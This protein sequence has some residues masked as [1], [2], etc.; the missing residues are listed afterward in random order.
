MVT[1]N[2]V[3]SGMRANHF[4]IKIA[5]FHLFSVKKVRIV[6]KKQQCSFVI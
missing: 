1:K 3:V 5:C 2:A 4:K 6:D